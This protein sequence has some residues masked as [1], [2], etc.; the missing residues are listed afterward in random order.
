MYPSHITAEVKKAKEYFQPLFF[1]EASKDFSPG[2]WTSFVDDAE[3]S[4]PKEIL[5]MICG[6]LSEASPPI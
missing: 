4:S 6:K 2:G 3:T 1:I 5:L